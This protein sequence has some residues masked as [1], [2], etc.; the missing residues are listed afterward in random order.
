VNFPDS[1]LKLTAEVEAAAALQ[2]LGD[3]PAMA[4][5][6]GRTNGVFACVTALDPGNELVIRGRL[7]LAESELA[8]ENFSAALAT[9]KLL[10]PPLLAPGLDWQ[11]ANLWCRVQA[12]MGDWE[13]ALA[14]TT[15]LLQL[16]RSQAAARLA[17]SVAWR[18]TVLERL[19]R[20]ADA[21][22]AWS[23]CLTNSAPPDWQRE[24]VLRIARA[25][26]AQHKF[27][28]AESALN[29]YLA[30]YPKSESAELARLTLGELQLK[31]YAADATAT[32]Q[33]AAA[34]TAFAQLIAGANK[35]AAVGS[36]LTGKALLDRG[37]CFW[38][39]GQ[40]AGNTNA[41]VKKIAA[42]LEDFSAAVK[43]LSFSEDLAV[44]K[45]KQGD[46]QFALGKFAE[47]TNSYQSMLE[48]FAKVDSVMKSLGDRALYQTLRASLELKDLR[49]ADMAM[50]QMLEK[51]PASELADNSLLLL[52]QGF[53]EAG[54]TTNA[55]KTFQDF[56]LLF[57]ES[58][59]APQVQLARARAL[60]A[61]Q[62]GPAAITNYQ[63]WLKNYPT[64]ELRPQVEYA[65]G[66]AS[67]LNGDEMG[68]LAVFTNFIASFPADTN[69]AL[70]QWWVADHYF[71]LGGTN[72]LAAEKN[73]EL[74]FQTPAWRDATNLYYLAQLMA[75]RSA[76]ARQGFG[77]ANG[78]Y[79]KLLS[80]T[81]CADEIKNQTRF[82]YAASLMQTPAP[83]TN[84]PGL[85]FQLATNILAQMPPTNALGLLALSQMA[86]CCLQQGALAVATNYYQL[87][88][89]SP[90]A[91]VTLRS[92]AKVGLGIVLEKM[93]ASL[94]P[95]NA[96]PFQKAALENYRD[97]FYQNNLRNGEVADEFWLKKA[98]LQML[99]LAVALKDGE[100][101]KMIDRLEAELPPLKPAL[102]KKRA[103]LKN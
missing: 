30:K 2:K 81:N 102:E 88:A 43:A 11:R 47:A 7:L 71:R 100:V 82:A 33:L 8:Q 27:S 69:A 39:A 26:L 6:L 99:P 21:S 15:N 1:P 40:S 75:G 87:V 4:S 37:W 45:F 76:A 44:A 73:Y 86:D 9:L 24:A 10:N 91:D 77:D 14:T 93:A 22:A 63:A 23:E 96:R 55:L 67:F 62:N 65:L 57:P 98:G 52:G 68:A 53:S 28:E 64:N 85:N 92:R 70:A 42:S 94:P 49:A 89:G 13:G 61:G 84:N 29:D 16:A 19:G 25:A 31:E 97:V 74:I 35:S 38:L 54:A 12:G 80:D 78:Y 56:I 101:D 48:Q 32:N 95:E 83:D 20:W 79:L 50:R 72:Y 36:P 60:E 41:A 18:G 103:A 3:W 66:R 59:L 46:A 17:D 90:L 51:Y 34:Q 58:A 5:L